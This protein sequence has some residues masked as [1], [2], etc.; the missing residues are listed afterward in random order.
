MKPIFLFIL[1]AV[2]FSRTSCNYGK[3]TFVYDDDPISEVRCSYQGICEDLE[4]T[5]KSKNLKFDT[6]VV[7]S[8]VNDEVDDSTYVLFLYTLEKNC[9]LI[10]F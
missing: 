5:F 6:S 3:D 4:K 7:R 1:Y 2:S 9:K 10:M 8:C